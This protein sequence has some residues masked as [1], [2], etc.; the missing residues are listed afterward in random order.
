MKLKLTDGTEIDIKFWSFVKCYV[1]SGAVLAGIQIGL[2]LLLI[3]IF[4]V[5]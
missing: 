4:K 2:L 3:I 1:M 5:I